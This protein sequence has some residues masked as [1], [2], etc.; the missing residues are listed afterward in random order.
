MIRELASE[1]FVGGAQ[2]E[3]AVQQPILTVD[4]Q[5]C[6]G[7]NRPQGSGQLMNAVSGSHTACD[8]IPKAAVE[9]EHR[10]DLGLNRPILKAVGRKLQS[11]GE[12]VPVGL[13][14]AGLTQGHGGKG[15]AT[16]EKG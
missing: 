9:V 1:H 2:R 8:G 13:E 4:A 14:A 7:K 15:V 5:L 12:L 6:L 11:L 10:V 3:A 16:V